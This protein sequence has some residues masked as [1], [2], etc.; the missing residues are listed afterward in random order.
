MPPPI[1]NLDSV[2]KLTWFL[3]GSIK[4][5]AIFVE[6]QCTVAS[7]QKDNQKALLDLLTEPD[8]TEEVTMTENRLSVLAMV[9][10]HGNTEYIISPENLFA[11]SKLETVYM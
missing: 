4:R 10:I 6:V 1:R 5:K 11:E 9:L 2:Q 7:T 8:S 3:G